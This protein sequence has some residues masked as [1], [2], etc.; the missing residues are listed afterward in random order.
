MIFCNLLGKNWALDFIDNNVMSVCLTHLAGGKFD[1][2]TAYVTA[3]YRHFR[4][5]NSTEPCKLSQ[6]LMGLLIQT[7]EKLANN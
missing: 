2:V 7:W 1:H 5:E 4:N 3:G 6:R